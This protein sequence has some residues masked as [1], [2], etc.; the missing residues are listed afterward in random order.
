MKAQ[1]YAVSVQWGGGMHYFI[2]YSNGFDDAA[3]IADG[4]VDP[5]SNDRGARPTVFIWKQIRRKEEPSHGERS[6]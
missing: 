6:K 4:F 5:R 2:G 1:R 3:K